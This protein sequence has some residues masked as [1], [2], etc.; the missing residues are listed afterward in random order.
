MNINTLSLYLSVY[1]PCS[2]DT[3]SKLREWLS[4]A[5]DESSSIARRPAVVASAICA[6]ARTPL[7]GCGCGLPFPKATRS[8]DLPLPP[9][10]TDGTKMRCTCPRRSLRLLKST[11]DLEL[12]LVLEFIL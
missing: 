1:L 12:E 2:E 7:R 8:H 5:T 4:V 3:P 9:H 11:I 10:F 6:M